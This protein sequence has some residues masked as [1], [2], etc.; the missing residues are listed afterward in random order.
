MV[1]RIATSNNEQYE[2]TKDVK[3]TKTEVSNNVDYSLDTIDEQK[4]QEFKKMIDYIKENGGE[5]KNE[6]EDI[7]NKVIKPFEEKI[8]SILDKNKETKDLDSLSDEELNNIADE[9]MKNQPEELMKQQELIR[10]INNNGSPEE[11][12]QLN[13]MVNENMVDVQNFYNKIMNNTD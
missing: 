11:V 3:L 8:K 4:F 9:R 10:K 12:Q 13:E 7:M 1:E 5:Y 6:Y 2:V